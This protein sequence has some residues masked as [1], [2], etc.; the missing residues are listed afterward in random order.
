MQD[1]KKMI[2]QGVA[3]LEEKTGGYG[4]GGDHNQYNYSGAGRDNKGYIST[5]GRALTMDSATNRR[6]QRKS[7]K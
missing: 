2:S 4:A 3:R 5:K 7:G 1:P 6:Y